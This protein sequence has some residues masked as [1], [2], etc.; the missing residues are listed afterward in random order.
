MSPKNQIIKVQ[1]TGSLPFFTFLYVFN[2]P[3]I[4][5]VDCY[6]VESQ[7]SFIVSVEYF[8]GSKFPA[9]KLIKFQ[10]PNS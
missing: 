5:Q 3:L 6:L 9:Q 2:Y 7:Y 4:V 8:E 10:F 1:G